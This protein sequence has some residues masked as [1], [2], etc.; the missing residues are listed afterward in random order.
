MFQ[1]QGIPSH[2]YS[3]MQVGQGQSENAL[4]SNMNMTDGLNNISEQVTEEA[5]LSKSL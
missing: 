2:R 5:S 4:T 1:T 3:K